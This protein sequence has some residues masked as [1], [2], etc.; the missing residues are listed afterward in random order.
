MFIIITLGLVGA[1]VQVSTVCLSSLPWASWEPLYRSAQCVYHHYLGPRG[2]HCTGQHS[3][4]IIITLGLVGAT[5]QVS[6]VCLSSLPWALWEPL[7]RSA[8]CVYHHYL[9][10]CGSHCT[11]QHSVFIIITLGLVGAT[12]QVSTV[13]LS[14]LPW[15][16]WEP[17]YRSAQCVYHHYLG[18]CG[19]HCT[20]QHSVFIII[21]LGLVGATVQVS[22]VC[23]FRWWK[24]G[25]A[26]NELNFG[27]GL[28]M[29]RYIV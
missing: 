29:H 3:V 28:G 27:E 18:P 6:T 8:Q 10:P 11:G 5:V 12:V 22:T 21:T 17:L 23:C 25:D 9:G 7:Y 1:T 24:L 19:S 4:F 16:L 14:S 20:G 13:C 15:A 2:S 26:W